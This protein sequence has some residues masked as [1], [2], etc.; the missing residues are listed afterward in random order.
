MTARRAR[1]TFGPVVLAGLGSAGLLSL[2]GD[3]PWATV[4]A[5]GPRAEAA[6]AAVTATA[7]ES[8]RG[9]VPLALA[10]GLVVLACWG[11]LLVTRRRTRRVVAILGLVCSLGAVA[12]VITG[13]GVVRDSFDRAFAGTGTSAT[14]DFNAWIWVAGAAAVASVLATGLAVR[15]VATWPEMSSRYDAPAA[16]EAPPASALADTTDDE[17][18]NLEV[19]KSLDEGRDPTS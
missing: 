14:V 15:L 5:A 16:S 19:W 10:L 7:G 12:T 2:A 18:R 9:E 17:Q 1:S 11:V 4:S 8:G 13:R 3:R 6:T